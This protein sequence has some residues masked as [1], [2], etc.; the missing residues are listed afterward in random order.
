MTAIRLRE[1]P[2]IS[3]TLRASKLLLRASLSS[4]RCMDALDL[5]DRAAA[6]AHLA[7]L[8]ESIRDLQEVDYPM[9]EELTRLRWQEAKLAR[10]ILAMTERADTSEGVG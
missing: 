4:V 2:R 10:A 3:E 1:P 8:R 6:V 9:L 7:D 5:P